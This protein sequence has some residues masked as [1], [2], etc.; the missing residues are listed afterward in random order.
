MNS[1]AIS[2]SPTLKSGCTSFDGWDSD[3][4]FAQ[5]RAKVVDQNGTT[6]TPQK[7]VDTSVSAY[8]QDSQDSPFQNTRSKQYSQSRAVVHE[9]ETLVIKSVY[10]NQSFK[11]VSLQKVRSALK[12]YAS[13]NGFE[14]GTCNK[15]DLSETKKGMRLVMKC[16]LGGQSL[17]Q[18]W[19]M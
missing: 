18:S 2:H 15:T 4:D 10:L 1:E 17:K 16:T 7:K 11:T 8:C 5:P 12:K 13:N 9:E 3:D 6:S 14:L 19:G